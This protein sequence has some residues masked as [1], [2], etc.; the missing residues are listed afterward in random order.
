MGTG[1]WHVLLRHGILPGQNL[2]QLVKQQGSLPPERVVHLL[3]QVCGALREAHFVGL[4]HRDLKPS[5][6]IVCDRGG[7][8]DVAKL[9]D[10]GLVDAPHTEADLTG[11]G[12]IVGTPTY[13]SPEQA[14]GMTNLDARSDLYSLGATAYFML[15]G[16]PPFEL[17]TPIQTVAAHIHDRVTAPHLLRSDIPMDLSGCRTLL[18]E[19]SLEALS[20]CRESGESVR[21]MRMFEPLD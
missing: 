2:E 10:F 5:N 6:I 15:T 21:G 12:Q 19:G 7:I 4:I 14:A 17:T 16:K 3:R 1:G 13:M 9:L 8:C 18:G 11:V 20:G